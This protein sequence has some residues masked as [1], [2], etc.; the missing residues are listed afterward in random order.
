MAET[1]EKRVAE[2]ILQQPT[3][4]KVGNKTYAVAPPSVA[5]IILVSQYVAQLPAI[6]L[7][8]ERLIEDILGAAK[9]C[10]ALGDIAAVLLL[11]A[12]NCKQEVERKEQ[13]REPW[14]FGLLHRTREVIVKEVVNSQAEVAKELLE[15]L[16]ATELYALCMQILGTLQLADFFGLTT[17]LCEINLTRPTKVD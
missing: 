11:G 13:V 15:T 9:D 3:E 17:F 10:T 5:T 6:K 16:S 14:F 8:D 2:T 7:S 4:I 1:I 12:K